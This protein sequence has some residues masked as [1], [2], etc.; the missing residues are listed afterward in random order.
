MAIVLIGTGKI[1]S[2][3]GAVAFTKANNPAAPTW[4]LRHY[5]TY[6]AQ[7]HLNTD[8]LL[9]QM[10]NET[11]FMKSQ[12]SLPPYCNLAGIGATAD[13]VMGS[14][15]FSYENGVKEHCAHLFAYAGYAMNRPDLDRLARPWDDSLIDGTKET[16][17]DYVRRVIKANKWTVIYLTDLNAKWS[18][19]GATYGQDIENN[20]LGAYVRWKKAHPN[21]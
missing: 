12:R 7:L 13:N 9:P 18:W 21:V 1:I 4:A 5:W 20:F 19:P 15:N 14:K 8:A 16:R 10:W 3:A 17:F 2:L 11:N 6:A